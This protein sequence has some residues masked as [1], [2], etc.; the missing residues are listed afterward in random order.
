MIEVRRLPA[1]F[2]D[3]GARVS[4]TAMDYAIEVSQRV[5]V[6]QLAKRATIFLAGFSTILG[7]VSATEIIDFNAQVNKLPGWV[8]TLDIAEDKLGDAKH[9]LES[10]PLRTHMKIGKL[11]VISIPEKTADPKAASESLKLIENSYL[12]VLQSEGLRIDQVINTLDNLSETGQVSRTDID[13]QV[14]IIE[15]MEE[16]VHTLW[17]SPV[18][19]QWENLR[20][21][22]FPFELGAAFSFAGFLYLSMNKVRKKRS[23]SE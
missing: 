19:K 21:K 6:E 22:M 17:E 12:D 13:S 11:S 15:K 16:K 1:L 20:D 14:E 7:G 5:P 10:K 2:K 3:T 23:S 9:S 8:N 18:R 4:Y